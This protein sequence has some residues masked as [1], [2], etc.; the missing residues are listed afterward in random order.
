MARLAESGQQGRRM[1]RL[2]GAGLLAL[3]V[4]MHAA[5]AADGLDALLDQARQLAGAGRVEEAY[6][7][8]AAAEDEH[9]GE[10]RFDYALG[11]AALDA[12]QPARATLAF[13]RVLAVDPG[14]AGAIIDSGRAYLA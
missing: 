1:R 2:A 13:S 9:I 7:L 12:G 3:I 14:H 4:A 8:L 10:P 5:A 6:A 11:R